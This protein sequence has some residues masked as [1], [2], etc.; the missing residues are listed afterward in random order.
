MLL[1]RWA[2]LSATPIITFAICVVPYKL[3]EFFLHIEEAIWIARIASFT[4]GISLVSTI[5]FAF[6]KNVRSISKRC[7][8]SKDFIAQMVRVLISIF[9]SIMRD[10]SSNVLIL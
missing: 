9:A 8:P 6:R 10:S 2:V 1:C 7:M 3:Y 4:L 5:L